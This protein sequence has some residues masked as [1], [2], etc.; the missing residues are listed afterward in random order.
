VIGQLSR[1]AIAARE[2]GR[3]FMTRACGVTSSETVPVLVITKP[4]SDG[5]KQEF[6]TYRGDT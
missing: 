4:I 2:A 3:R 5:R 6:D 1:A